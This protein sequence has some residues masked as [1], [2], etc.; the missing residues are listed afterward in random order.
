MQDHLT[1][2]ES[3]YGKDPYHWDEFIETWRGNLDKLLYMLPSGWPLL[4]AE[5]D[6]QYEEHK[7]VDLDYSNAGFL[8]ALARNPDKAAYMVPFAGWLPL[9][10]KAHLFS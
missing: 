5:H 3:Q 9:L 6:R 7:S 10:Q 4:F 2:S 1:E 8:K